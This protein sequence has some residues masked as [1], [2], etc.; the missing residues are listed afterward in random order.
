MTP[1]LEAE[2]ERL[3]ELLGTQRALAEQQAAVAQALQDGRDG[4]ITARTALETALGEGGVLPQL[5]DTDPAE[6][7]LLATGAES[8]GAFVE[9][10]A[11]I[12]PNP[13]STLERQGNLALPVD[14]LILPDDGSGRPGVRIATAPRALVSTPVTATLLWQ[15]PLLDY[16]TVVLL[17]PAPD[18]IFVLAGVQEVFAETGLILPAGAPIGLM[19]DTQTFNDGILTENTGLETGQA[20]QSL[21]LEVREGQTAAQTDAWF[22]LE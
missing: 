15:G 8:L 12:R 7:S 17:E 20:A 2:A 16:G 6:A 5:F 14:G 13:D 10:L 1:V 4:A 22:A 11:A 3:A 9:T 18:L 19:P 21:Y